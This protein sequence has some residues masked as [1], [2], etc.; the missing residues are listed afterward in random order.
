MPRRFTRLFIVAVLFSM[1]FGTVLVIAQARGGRGAQGQAAA[2]LPRTR[3]GK[4]DL[5]GFW[6]SMT[7]ANFDIQD[8]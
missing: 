5:S 1:C 6:Q 3:E 8:N 4:P 2:P 7:T